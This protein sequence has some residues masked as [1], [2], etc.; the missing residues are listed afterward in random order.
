MHPERVGNIRIEKVLGQGGM[1]TVYLGFDEKL[2][3][4]VALKSIRSEQRMS[5]SAK[6]R[7][8]FE[9]RVLGKLE[10]PNICRIHDY[11]EDDE[12]AYLVL[13]YVEG[14]SLA[15]HIADHTLQDHHRLTIAIQI[16]DALVAA[17]AAGVIHRDLKPDNV[18]ITLDG[19]AK[20]LDFG[21][22]RSVTSESEQGEPAPH[23]A[24]T[25]PSAVTTQ[26][27]LDTP[28]QTGPLRPPTHSLL[29]TEDGTIMGTPLFMSPEQA[30]GQID[31]ITT[32]SDMYSFGLLLQTM[33]TSE[34]PYPKQ[35]SRNDLIARARAGQALPPSGLPK[36]IQQLVLRL[37]E[38]DPG[39]R[40]PA[41]QARH[42][43]RR[44][45]ARPARLLRQGA[46][47]LLLL[48][49]AA[50]AVKYT[51]DL[52]H[53]K[54]L[55]EDAA[56][57]QRRLRGV[58]DLRRELAEGLIGFMLDDLFDK[59][60]SVGKL[61]L[62]DDVDK[63]ALDYFAAIPEGELSAEEL[64]FRAQTLYQ[65]GEISLERGDLQ[66]ALSAFKDSLVLQQTIV[67][68]SP[69]NQT[70]LVQ[71]GYA[72]FWMGSGLWTQGDLD[73]AREQ[74][75]AS[76]EVAR[77]LVTLDPENPEYQLE[78]AAE[79]SNVAQVLEAQGDLVTAA[80]VMRSRLA[81]VQT[82]VDSDPERD[83]W[84][85]ELANSQL[86]LGRVLESQGDFAAAEKC[87]RADLQTMLELVGRDP[88]HAER[89]DRLSTSYSHLG[90]VLEFQ[91]MFD[92][93]AQCIEEQ[94]V[95]SERLAL[96]DA[97]NA[98]WRDHV[99]S[100]LSRLGALRI[101]AGEFEQ[102]R[103][104]MRRALDIFFELNAQDPTRTRWRDESLSVS[105]ILADLLRQLG[106]RN[107]ALEVARRGLALTNSLDVPS[108]PEGVREDIETLR[109]LV[110]EL[111][112]SPG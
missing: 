65:L 84:Q 33:W 93:A 79:E 112:R 104:P 39:D 32:A 89:L 49:A 110:S 76:A 74:F 85:L 6:L 99:A 9:A 30:R 87:Y 69:D 68:E 92:E 29:V 37:R 46:V 42:V 59:L 61:E 44:Y 54:G 21:L 12:A 3:R 109:D 103:V 26:G 13:E 106:E 52:R 45:Q 66:T 27:P 95:V 23:S 53:Q 98:G 91:E 38:V 73:Q 25:T 94:Q 11:I 20:V 62:L 75:E 43:L 108:L 78:L 80:Q 71:L 48:V 14:H 111:E 36:Q 81:T 10:H 47:A 15:A 105:E 70:A 35:L 67:S 77:R 1:G 7:F 22:A 17:H 58:A 101:S 88:S 90:Q 57:E 5:E 34:S 4:T 60:R 16:A 107:A 64:T 8:Q 83:D 24:A 19:D 41:V 56:Q 63:R 51:V 40:M 100:G 55:A 31:E 82:L 2:E 102:A 50:A 96:G 28:S 72:H 86:L 18:V 97:D